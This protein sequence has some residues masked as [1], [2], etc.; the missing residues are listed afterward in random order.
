MFDKI[1]YAKTGWSDLYK[2]GAVFGRHD[3]ISEFEEAHEKFNFLEGPEAK[4]YGYIPPIG[5]EFRPPKP[6]DAFGW[7]VVFV[8][9]QNGHGPLTV[10]GWYELATFELEY[11]SRPEYGTGVDFET[12]INGEDYVYCVFAKKATLIPTGQ[13]TF[14][15][16]GK[17]FRRAPIVYVKGQGKNEPWREE[18][19]KYAEQIVSNTRLE[20]SESGLPS[21]GFPDYDHR[22][23]VE[24]ASVSAVSKYLLKNGY[25]VTDRQKENCGYD[26]L[27]IGKKSPQEL[28]VEVKGTSTGIP[29]F[30]ITR[31]EMNYM[32]NAKWRLAIVT[33]AL[34]KPKIRLL[35][36]KVV[37]KSFVF[38]PLAWCARLK[39]GA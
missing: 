3:Y 24:T 26:L 27:A 29:N 16:S 7:L 22:K 15:I 35:T 19:A 30:F 36:E 9:A 8:A 21:V 28:H 23:K 31:N 10:I 12:D 38:D 37:R 2:G 6:K 39:Y 33:E 14:I 4:F 11:K 13:R 1:M 5:K 20:P 17:H 18:L 25:R 32:T 34:T